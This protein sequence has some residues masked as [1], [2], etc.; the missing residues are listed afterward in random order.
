M[1]WDFA[2]LVVEILKDGF[3]H[4]LLYLQTKGQS[5]EYN[6]T[7]DSDLDIILLKNLPR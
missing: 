7:T 4:K 5:F 2:R 6:D 1:T 3:F